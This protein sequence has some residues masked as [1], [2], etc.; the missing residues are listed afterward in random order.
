MVLAATVGFDEVG[1]LAEIFLSGPEK[2]MTRMF[3]FGEDGLP[4]GRDSH[5]VTHAELEAMGNPE[6]REARRPGLIASTA[7]VGAATRFAKDQRAP[8]ALC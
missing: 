3:E 2:A 7:V 4:D 8:S 5:P 6:C 1:R